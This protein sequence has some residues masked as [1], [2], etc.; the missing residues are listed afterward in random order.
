[1]PT[2]LAHVDTDGRKAP[3]RLCDQPPLLGPGPP[4]SLGAGLCQL[5]SGTPWG[6]GRDALLWADTAASRGGRSAGVGSGG[7]A[8]TVGRCAGAQAWR[9]PSPRGVL[10]PER[11]LECG[12]QRHGSCCRGPQFPSL[13]KWGMLPPPVWPPWGEGRG[14]CAA[15]L[16]SELPQAA[17]PL[18][19][20]PLP[21]SGKIQEGLTSWILCQPPALR[22]LQ[23]AT[24][25][26]PGP[27]KEPAPR[28]PSVATA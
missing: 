23:V 1:M 9:S 19:H 21:S 8:G 6:L 2:W 18:P 10:S 22:L 15:I 11:S 26:A 28:G 12:G 25:P 17:C 3:P 7:P 24:S 4:R 27:Q 14:R 20:A 5:G 13:Q 16:G